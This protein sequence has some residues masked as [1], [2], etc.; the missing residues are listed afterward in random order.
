MRSYNINIS[1]YMLLMD[2]ILK[3]HYQKKCYI[4]QD[5]A[6]TYTFANIRDFSWHSESQDQ[7]QHWITESFQIDTIKKVYF[8][9]VPFGP[10]NMIAH[11]MVSF[12]FVDWRELCLS[13]EAA[14]YQWEEYGFFK[15]LLGFYNIMFIWGTQH[16]HVSLRTALRGERVQKFLLDIPQKHAKEL[17]VSLIKATQKVSKKRSR[18]NLIWN[19]CLTSI[20]HIASTRFNLP[21][22]NIALLFARFTPNF[23]HK[24]DLLNVKGKRILR[25]K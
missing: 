25:E 3:P 24:L 22:W 6:S 10:K 14:L 21:R 20:W 8:L 2:K 23:L 7:K 12:H 16:D 9:Y 1:P 18:Y 11:S 5:D 17:F 4:T 13:V 15:A 19:N